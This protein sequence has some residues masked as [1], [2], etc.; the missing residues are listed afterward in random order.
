MFVAGIREFFGAVLP[1]IG[2]DVVSQHGAA[3]KEFR[4]IKECCQKGSS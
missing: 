1:S 2:R 3:D 4:N